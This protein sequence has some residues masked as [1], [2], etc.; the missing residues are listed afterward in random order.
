MLNYKKLINR[1]IN[2]KFF[3]T[4]SICL[5]ALS[6]LSLI[7]FLD[8]Y[9]AIMISL[10]ISITFFIVYLVV[11]KLITTKFKKI[12][13]KLII[14]QDQSLKLFKIKNKL[15]KDPIVF[16]DNNKNV[17]AISVFKIKAIPLS[18]QTNFLKLVR[19]V[20]SNNIN[21]FTIY[22]YSNTPDMNQLN[23]GDIDND[24]D[25]I[26]SFP[27]ILT[28]NLDTSLD[29][30]EKW[31]TNILFGCYIKSDKHVNSENIYELYKKIEHKLSILE[32]IFSGSFPHGKLELLHGP[33]L[34][35]AIQSITIGGNVEI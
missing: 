17:Y 35:R 28:R 29:K 22:S 4:G 18:I 30:T 24:E 27:E 16:L 31:I 19:G 7:S 2:Y 11:L 12:D 15:R 21:F 14:K 25:W 9:I 5:M 1:I 32:S 10:V 26:N 3:I 34:F 23:N 33:R 8:I 20:A 13:N 6:I